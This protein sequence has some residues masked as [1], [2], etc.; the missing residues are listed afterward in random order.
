[1]AKVEKSKAE[2]RS[3]FWGYL[4]LSI[5]AVVI[6][7]FGY[8]YY[9]M[10]RPT[11]EGRPVNLSVCSEAH[12]DFTLWVESRGRAFTTEEVHGFLRKARENCSGSW[13]VS[14][15]KDVCSIISSA[16]PDQG[17]R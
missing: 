4:L 2:K 14:M 11:M 10:T 1:M 15:R 6:A 5:F 12:D 9:D 13:Y 16:C 8:F 3:N 7:S 17:W